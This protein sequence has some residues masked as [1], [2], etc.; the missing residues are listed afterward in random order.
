MHVW[1][2]LFVVIA[3]EAG[4]CHH[5]PLLRNEDLEAPDTLEAMDH[6]AANRAVCDQLLPVMCHGIEDLC[7]CRMRWNEI[8]LVQCFF[9]CHVDRA[10]HWCGQAEQSSVYKSRVAGV[11]G[12]HCS[13]KRRITLDS[14]LQMSDDGFRRKGPNLRSLML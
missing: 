9:Q 8:A 7:W 5:V 2:A 4:P 10:V 11:Y 14:K 13:R 1:S 3:S 12:L 6:Q